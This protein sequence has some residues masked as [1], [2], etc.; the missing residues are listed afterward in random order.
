MIPK[1]FI[2]DW[3]KQAPWSE[4]YQVEQDLVLSRCLVEIY[5]CHSVKD[6]IAFRGGTALQKLFLEKPARYSEDIDLVQIK[7]A[8]IGE[9]LD[10]IRSKL[11]SLFP[12][13][14]QVDRQPCG[15]GGAKAV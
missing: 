5:N 8:P 12:K 11:D 6:T 2:Q 1:A 7:N 15:N 9:V 10:E 14:P 4:S 3:R 13:K